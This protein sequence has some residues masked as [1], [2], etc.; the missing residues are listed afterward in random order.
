MWTLP[1]YLNLKFNEIKLDYLKFS[2]EQAEKFLNELVR[3]GDNISKKAHAV[4]V[5]AISIF[6]LSLSAWSSSVIKSPELIVAAICLSSISFVVVVILIHPIWSYK[7]YVSG[8]DPSSLLKQELV[9][10]FSDQDNVL[11]NLI[12]TELV[13]YQYRIDHNDKINMHRIKYVDRAMFL[14]VAAP[15]LSWLFGELYTVLF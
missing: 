2:F 12:L 5:I 15:I 4:L 8:S 10:S 7:T 9:E 6:T 3:T 14:L 1:E 11:K 13:N